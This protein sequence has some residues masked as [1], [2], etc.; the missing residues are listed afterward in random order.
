MGT[1]RRN[2]AKN[3][4][5]ASAAFSLQS[6]A[7]AGVEKK[8]NSKK[9][10]VCLGGHPDDPECGCGGTLAKLVSQGH[11]VTVIYL[12]RGEAGIEGK[13]HD[14]AA[15]IRTKESVA[16][17][18][19][20]NARPVF[21]G[22]IDGESVVNNEWINKVKSLITDEKPDIVFA[23]WPI[24]THKDHQCASILTIQAWVR[25]GR[26]FALY[27]F[28]TCSGSQTTGFKPTDYV[29]ISATQEQKRK[30]VFCHESQNPPGLYA[31]SGCN[32]ATMEKFRG[33]EI[34]VAAAEAFVRI[35]NEYI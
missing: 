7:N 20:L 35:G 4:L 8:K 24:D 5:A 16:A 3:I 25:S 17:C 19:V 27:F 18:R 11:E 12:T 14:E 30:A 22:Q 10:I 2:F 26:N 33:I 1:S 28:E 23:H 9:K 15:A 13:S 31:S 34:N 32:H 21:A 29:D 6:F